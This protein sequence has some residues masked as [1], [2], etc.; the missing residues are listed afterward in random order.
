MAKPRTSPRPGHCRNTV[1]R[2]FEL[3]G[4]PPTRR[5]STTSQ[6]S[7]SR[8]KNG[9]VM[10]TTKATSTAAAMTTRSARAA[11]NRTTSGSASS[12]RPTA[13]PNVAAAGHMR[14]R[15][16]YAT[17]TSANVTSVRLPF[18]SSH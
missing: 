4:G 9:S 6:S 10:R 12:L 8:S 16:R 5:E 14:A 7:Q 15:I 3:V 18:A 11:R 1:G 17:I 2:R 13:S